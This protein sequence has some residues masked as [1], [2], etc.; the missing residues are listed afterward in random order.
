MFVLRFTQNNLVYLR[1]DNQMKNKKKYGKP[2]LAGKINER[3]TLDIGFINERAFKCR[4]LCATIKQQL[5]F[6]SANIAV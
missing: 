4:S 6:I 2:S 5:K 3:W 1:T